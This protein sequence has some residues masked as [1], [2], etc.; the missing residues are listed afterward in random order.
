VLG[1]V[2]KTY[3]VRK[4]SLCVGSFAVLQAPAVYIMGLAE[5]F[6]NK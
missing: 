1:S 5:G 2:P 6:V 4:L 3:K